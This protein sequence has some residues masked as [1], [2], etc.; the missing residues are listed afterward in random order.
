MPTEMTPAEAAE[1]LEKLIPEIESGLNTHAYD[2]AALDYALSLCRKV[3]AGELREVV[4][5]HSV[6]VNNGGAKTERWCSNCETIISKR[7][8][9][10]PYCG[11]L[12]DGKGGSD[13]Q[14]D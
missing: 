2:R 1:V 13:G 6:F 14:A 9:Y 10:C 4:H 12:M 3:A 5:A 7:A 11:A 8:K